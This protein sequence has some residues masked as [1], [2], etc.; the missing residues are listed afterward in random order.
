MGTDAL[1]G[2]N[3]DR[4]AADP[5][6]GGVTEAHH[7]AI[8]H[9]EIEACGGQRENHDTREQRQHEDIA[10]DRSIERKQ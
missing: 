9:D 7:P 8:S 1:G 10:A 3:A 2:E 5:E 6:I 4:V